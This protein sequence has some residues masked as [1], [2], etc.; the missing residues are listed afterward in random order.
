MKPKVFISKRIPQEVED[1]IAQYC[2]YKIWNEETP[3]P[4]DVLL[5][6][7]ADV[8]GLMTPKGIITKEF[9]NNAPNLKIVSN[10]AVGYDAFDI[11]AMKERDVWGTNTPFVLDEAVADLAFGLILATSRRVVEFN[12]YVKEGKWDRVLD[13]E[14]S[15]GKDVHHS[16][17]GIIGMGRIGEKVA[18]RAALGFEM[19]V[20]YY[21]TKRKPELE[22]KYGITYS[23]MES[24]L[25]RSDFVLL[26]VPLRE[27][28][29]HLMGE[30]QFSLMKS[31]AIFINC[32]RGQTVNEN[33]LIAA[34]Q[35]GEIRGAGLD[36][37]EKEPVAVDNPILKMDN[38]VVLP[39]IGSATQ[40]TR[41]DMAMKAAENLV[42][43]VTGQ[44]PPDLVK[45]LQG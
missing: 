3:I 27:S 1:Y 16:T 39:H 22:E 4:N 21:N 26:L 8:E 11:E 29:Y 24:L 34:L 35:S 30:K 33:A 44:V 10:I 2:N 13:S 15:F 18:R 7:V 45:E 25:E 5:K 9:L 19:D 20:L 28:T 32:S 43:G 38:V 14:E 36:V 40:K 23:D 31:S 37:F 42:A 41:F 12:N 17:L 6:E